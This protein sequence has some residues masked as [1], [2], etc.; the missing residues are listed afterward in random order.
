MLV[1]SHTKI[2]SICEEVYKNSPFYINCYLQNH[3]LTVKGNITWPRPPGGG[4]IQI[5]YLRLK[6][7]PFVQFV[8]IDTNIL[9]ENL[10]YL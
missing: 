9:L 4:T 7:G 10:W 1:D 5:I 6:H 2:S 3:R 8:F